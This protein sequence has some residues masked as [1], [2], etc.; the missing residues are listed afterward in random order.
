LLHPRSKAPFQGGVAEEETGVKKESSAIPIDPD[1]PNVETEGPAA[2]DARIDDAVC[3]QLIPE[4]KYPDGGDISLGNDYALNVAMH[5]VVN[6][7]G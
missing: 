7:A 4:I 5:E 3:E 2:T 1:G 6:T